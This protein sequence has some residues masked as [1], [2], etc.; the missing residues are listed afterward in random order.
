MSKNFTMDNTIS[1]ADHELRA[2]KNII[3]N[4]IGQVAL[5]LLGFVFFIYLSSRLL[6]AGMGKYGFI[7]SFVV[8]WFIFSDFGI[9]GHLFREWAKKEKPFSEIEDDFYLDFTLRFM[10]A[11]LVFVPFIIINYYINN[12]IFFPLILAY[13]STFFAIFSNLADS[14]L[15]SNNAFRNISIRQV[16]EKLVIVVVGGFLIYIR[17]SL[18]LLF[19]ATIIGQLASLGYYYATVLP[20]KFRF[21]F[22]WPKTYRLA[23]KGLPFVFT[24]LLLSIYARIDIVMLRFMDGF[25]SVGW[26]NTAYRFIDLAAIFSASLFMPSIFTIL[27]SL[28]NDEDKQ[29][30]TAF[31]NKSVR[32][33]FSSSLA[34][35]LGIIFFSPLAIATFFPASF[36]PATL[37]L[38]I[39]ILAQLIGTFSLLFNNLLIIQHREKIGLYIILFSAGF[40]IALNFLLIPRYSLYGAAWATVIAEV[41]NLLLI[42]RYAIWPKNYSLIFKMVGVSVVNITVGLML[43]YFG[44]LNNIFVGVLVLLVNGAIVWN[45]D[46]LRSEDI[47][48]FFRPIKV[49]YNA[50]FNNEVLS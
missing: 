43:K 4:A 15:Q 33:L 42:Q 37:A 20:F 45:V 7:G 28:H 32:I 8:P 19:I 25:E 46:L 13:I 49:K 16:L 26:Y 38:R 24:T 31:F 30:F 17:P 41:A 10:M 6:E 39:L 9:G 36:S 12:E 40:N 23:R 34:I 14:F 29:K 44:L 35:T 5:R 50:L 2:G 48:L 27:S 22:D 11:S 18:N 1:S 3:W 21:V 47:D